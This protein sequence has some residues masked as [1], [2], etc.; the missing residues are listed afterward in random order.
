MIKLEI[1]NYGGLSLLYHLSRS[2]HIHYD[3]KM[4]ISIFHNEW[5]QILFILLIFLS[6]HHFFIY[7]F[8]HVS[9]SNR[10]N[11]LVS[12]FPTLIFIKSSFQLLLSSLILDSVPITDPA[13]ATTNSATA[14][15]CRHR[16]LHCPTWCSS[17]SPTLHRQTSLYLSI[18]LWTSQTLL[19]YS[20]HATVL[21]NIQFTLCQSVCNTTRCTVSFSLCSCL[22]L[23]SS[24]LLL[25]WASFFCTSTTFSYPFSFSF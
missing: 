1:Y 22:L 25:Q 23:S 17:I 10:C 7:F 21:Y 3:S 12:S 15:Q 24:I 2:K 4:Y 18:F 13:I 19:T 9:N 11:S 16:Y 8:S 5:I 6:L 20:C 14:H